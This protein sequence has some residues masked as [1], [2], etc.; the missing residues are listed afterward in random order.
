MSFRLVPKSM[1]LNDLE[2]R[3]GR[4]V[5][6]F[7]YNFK[8]RPHCL[9]SDSGASCY[10]YL[11]HVTSLSSCILPG[12]TLTTWRLDHCVHVTFFKIFVH[13]CI[14]HISVN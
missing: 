12:T 4:Y 13:M 1:A 10:F 9:L 6:L 14:L 11:E 5:A 8:P 3:N 7:F 2:W